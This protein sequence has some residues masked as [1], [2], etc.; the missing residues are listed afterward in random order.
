MNISGPF[1]KAG[2]MKT[3]TFLNLK[4][5]KLKSYE[6]YE[7]WNT[8]FFVWLDANTVFLISGLT[9]SGRPLTETGCRAV[10]TWNASKHVFKRYFGWRSDSVLLWLAAED[11][12]KVNLQWAFR[13]LTGKQCFWFCCSQKRFTPN[14]NLCFTGSVQ[15]PAHGSDEGCGVGVSVV[16]MYVVNLLTAVAQRPPWTPWRQLTGCFF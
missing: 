15:Q 13:K 7:Y 14:D 6:T 9:N 8:L 12:G 2:L 11:E 3:L 5:G 4:W 16:C 10:W 1:Q